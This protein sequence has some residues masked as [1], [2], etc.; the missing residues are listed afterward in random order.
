M[1]YIQHSQTDNVELR[2]SFTIIIIIIIDI[3]KVA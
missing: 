1:Y 3:F 2:S